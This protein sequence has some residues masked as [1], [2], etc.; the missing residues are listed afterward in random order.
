MPDIKTLVIINALLLFPI[1]LYAAFLYKK[2]P[3]NQPLRFA[4]YFFISLFIA[5][6]FI[7]LRNKIPDFISI[8]LANTL[9]AMSW[10]YLYL[11]VSSAVEPSSKWLKRYFIPVGVIFIGFIFFTHLHNDVNIRLIITY[12]FVL[13][14]FSLCARVFWLHWQEKFYYFDRASALF[15]LIIPLL[16]SILIFKLTFKNLPL[17]MLSIN[18]TVFAS[19]LIFVM[20]LLMWFLIFMNYRVKNC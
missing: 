14:M 7:A 5:F 9:I 4:F 2:S 20:F 3:L 10:I 16:S 15:F 13:V 1:G 19:T 12:S 17:N 6:V 11:S 8:V 18:E